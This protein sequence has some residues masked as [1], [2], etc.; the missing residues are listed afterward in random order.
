MGRIDSSFRFLADLG[1]ILLVN[2]FVE[3][4]LESASKATLFTAAECR[5]LQ[6][7]IDVDLDSQLLC[8]WLC[9][10]VLNDDSGR[11]GQRKW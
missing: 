5:L 7:V 1:D 10:I 2:F 11:W 8:S 4:S 6:G 3:V 9:L